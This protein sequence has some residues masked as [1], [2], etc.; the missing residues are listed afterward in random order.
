VAQKGPKE[1]G[2]SLRC[3]YFCCDDGWFYKPN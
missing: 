1:G 3:R 2:G